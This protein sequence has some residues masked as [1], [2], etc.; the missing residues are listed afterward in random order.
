MGMVV[1][2]EM[3]SSAIVCKRQ[4]ATFALFLPSRR[5]EPK[6]NRVLYGCTV[7]VCTRLFSVAP[8]MS[9]SRGWWTPRPPPPAAHPPPVCPPCSSINLIILCCSSCW[10]VFPLF[11]RS[12]STPAPSPPQLG[13][14]TCF[15]SRRAALR[16]PHYL[17]AASGG[18]KWGYR[19]RIESRHTTTTQKRSHIAFAYFIT[20]DA[21]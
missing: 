1:I 18:G 14:G 5:S 21:L 9:H 11:L 12:V 13:W 16:L 4:V 20:E 2:M 15:Q 3:I 10:A 8:L 19:S 7:L 17:R 6:V